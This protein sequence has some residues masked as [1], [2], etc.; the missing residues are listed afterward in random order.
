MNKQKGDE[1]NSQEPIFIVTALFVYLVYSLFAI[2][3]PGLHY[4]VLAGLEL[5]MIPLSV[6]ITTGVY[7][8]QKGHSF[9]SDGSAPL[10]RSTAPAVQ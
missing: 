3:R 6:R 9:N 1:K 8:V 2:L 10:R 4:V 5:A 7:T